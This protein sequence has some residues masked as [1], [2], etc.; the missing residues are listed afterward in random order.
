MPASQCPKFLLP[1][2]MSVEG[3]YRHRRYIKPPIGHLQQ[4]AG[5]GV[6]CNHKITINSS[7]DNH[8]KCKP[9]P[10]PPLQ[11]V[12]KCSTCTHCSAEQYS[13]HWLKPGRQYL[14]CAVSKRLYIVFICGPKVNKKTTLLPYPKLLLFLESQIKTLWSFRQD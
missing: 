8:Q 7:Q 2:P 6:S 5:D 12:H 4:R 9:M 14:S 10:G 1:A 11:T 13:K 3:I